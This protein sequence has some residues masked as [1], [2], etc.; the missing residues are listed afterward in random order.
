MIC[1]SFTPNIQPLIYA[2]IVTHDDQDN[3]HSDYLWQI[4]FLATR[5]QEKKIQNIFIDFP[6]DFIGFINNP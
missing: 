4:L 2:K 5:F 1:I 3:H 6:V